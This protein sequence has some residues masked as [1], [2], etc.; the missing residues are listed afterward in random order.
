MQ[1]RS[2][3][4]ETVE[5]PDYGDS[6]FPQTSDA[7]LPADSCSCQDNSRAD[8][9]YPPGGISGFAGS[10]SRLISAILT[11]Q[12]PPAVAFAFLG[13]Q[14]ATPACLARAR[15]PFQ[16]PAGP[17]NGPSPASTPGRPRSPDPRGSPGPRPD[18]PS[19]PRPD[20]P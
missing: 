2:M 7:T 4:N 10:M 14:I 8:Y 5:R 17:A 13:S 12:I 1:H 16:E 3:L 15:R 9:S 20:A 11:T 19:E 18:R 6:V